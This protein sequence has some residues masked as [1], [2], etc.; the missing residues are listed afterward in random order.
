M[1]KMCSKKVSAC[2]AILSICLVSLI[3]IITFINNSPAALAVCTPAVPNG[4]CVAPENAVNCPQ[5]CAWAAPP[6]PGNVPIDLN[7]T[8]MNLTNW[9][10]GFVTLVAVL[11]LIWGGVNYLTSAGDED[12]VK[13]GKRVMEYAIMGIVV[14]GFAYAIVVVIVSTILV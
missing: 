4:A 1:K 8:I 7:Q 3:S 13:T 9:I 2:V 6:R 10:L 5:D 12:K 14:C 11:A